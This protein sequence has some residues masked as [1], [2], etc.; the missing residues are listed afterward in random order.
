MCDTEQ[1][2]NIAVSI[3]YD[4]RLQLF[5]K[6]ITHPYGTNASKKCENEMVNKYKWLLLMIMQMKTKQNTIQRCRIFQIIH[7]E[8]Y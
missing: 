6:I 2:N 8:Y 4:K 5:D 3:N 7:T 1:I